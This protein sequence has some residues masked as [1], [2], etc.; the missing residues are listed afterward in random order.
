MSKATV[1][2][3]AALLALPMQAS[4]QQ[5]FLCTGLGEDGREEAASFAHTLK[6]VYAAP[7]G[8]YLG[9]VGIRVARG[10]TVI[11]DAVC[12]GPWLLL[13][14]EPG[15]YSVTSSYEGQTRSDTVRVGG[16]RAVEKTI[17]LKAN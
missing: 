9:Q 1:L 10:E 16:G 6:L 5:A 11:Y 3:C 12:D 15:T 17:I 8:N 13:N 2:F 14:V 4:A 7:Q